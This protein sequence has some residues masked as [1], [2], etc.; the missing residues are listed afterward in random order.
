MPLNPKNIFKI[1]IKTIQG[2]STLH[3][4]C[5]TNKIQINSKMD[6]KNQKYK[7]KANSAFI[8][9]NCTLKSFPTMVDKQTL[10]NN[11]CIPLIIKKN[12]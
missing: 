3:N 2:N 6:Q 11:A 4:S 5:Y 9:N 10:C 1:V 12:N 7:I 8:D